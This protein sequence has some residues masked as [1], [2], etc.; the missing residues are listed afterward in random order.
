MRESKI[1]L[2]IIKN[3]HLYLSVHYVRVLGKMG[4]FEGEETP[5]CRK[6]RPDGRPQAVPVRRRRSLTGID[7]RA[8]G[9]LPPQENR[10]ES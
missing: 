9:F 7:S 10:N 8:K 2:H 1:S 4:E 3:V 6:Q 5:F